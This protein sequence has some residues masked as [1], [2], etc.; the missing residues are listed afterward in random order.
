MMG[1]AAVLY[2]AGRLDVA[3]MAPGIAL[4][5]CVC[6]D[7][8]PGA[9]G[10][11]L[12][13]IDAALSAAERLLAEPPPTSLMAFALAH[14]AAVVAATEPPAGPPLSGAG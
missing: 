14:G 5:R 9:A 2:G 10:P 12:A 13:R 11:A 8:D 4:A 1:F 6:R 3:R 7:P